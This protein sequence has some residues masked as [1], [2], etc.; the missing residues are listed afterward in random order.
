[1]QKAA[2]CLSLEAESLGNKSGYMSPFA[3]EARKHY[4]DFY[5]RGKADD[6][7]VIVA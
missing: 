3:K 5:P 7:T 6:V 1:V 4:I 2:E